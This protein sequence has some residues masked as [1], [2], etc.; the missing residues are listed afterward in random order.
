[1]R[2]LH[3]AIG[4]ATEIIELNKAIYDNKYGDEIPLDITN[5]KE[6]I[7]DC[8]WYVGI[9]CDV[10]DIPFA[11][12]INLINTRNIVFDFQLYVNKCEIIIGEILDLCKRHIFYRAKYDPTQMRNL[13]IEL[14]EELYK[15]VL[16]LKSDLEEELTKNI[17]KLRARFPDKYTDYHAVNRNLEV[18]RQ[19]LEK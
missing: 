12:V 17:D 6:E 10:L 1:L 4:L 3:S 2:L 14:I 9:G 5:I 7:Q 19:I 8:F 16:A 11:R 13:Y 15:A 18:E